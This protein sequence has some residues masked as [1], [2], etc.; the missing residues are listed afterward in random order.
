MKATELNLI[1][2]LQKPNVQFVIPVYQRNYDWTKKECEQLFL[3]TLKVGQEGGFSSHFI[4]SIVFIHDSAYSS[5]ANELT[6][7]DGQQRLTTITL[8]WIAIYQKAKKLKDDKLADMV[9]RLYLI[10]E[11]LDDDA[12]IKL[13]YA[14]TLE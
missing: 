8:I 11:F 9:Y 4:G 10:N 2:L 3:D 13:K 7:I 5:G 14:I 12:K 1:Q 6:I